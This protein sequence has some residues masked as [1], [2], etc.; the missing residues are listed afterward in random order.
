MGRLG[1]A[2]EGAPHQRSPRD[3]RILKRGLRPVHD[4][5]VYQQSNTG[6]S[7][8]GSY[9]TSSVAGAVEKFAAESST[10]YTLPVKGSIV[11]VRARCPDTEEPFTLA[12][13]ALE[14]PGDQPHPAVWIE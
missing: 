10:E 8:L 5:L 1:D 6:T 3:Q 4:W 2:R 14:G 9:A 11:G 13:R 12:C 7:P